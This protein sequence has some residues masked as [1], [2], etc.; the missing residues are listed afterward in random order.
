MMERVN[1]AENDAFDGRC[2]Q[3]NSDGCRIK[4]RCSDAVGEAM[5]Y[6]VKPFYAGL[7]CAAGCI[8]AMEKVRKQ[9]F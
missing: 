8:L 4:R 9:I 2:N 7:D 5:M 3:R 6:G 1:D